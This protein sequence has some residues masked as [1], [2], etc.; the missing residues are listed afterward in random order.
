MKNFIQK[1]EVIDVVLA[2]IITSGTA[3]LFTQMFGV[4]QKSG[5]IG[6]TVPFVVEGVFDLPYGVAATA[7]VGDLI[8]WDDSTKNVTKTASSNKKIGFCVKDA[9]S[10]DATMRVR[11]VPTI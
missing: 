11:L 5:A 4:A 1:G 6:D 10:S 8:Y 3:R 2:A 9:A 7:A